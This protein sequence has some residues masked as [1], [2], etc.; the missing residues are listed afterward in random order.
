MKVEYCVVGMVGTN[1][2]FA[3]NEET[4]ECLVIDPGD[5]ASALIRKLDEQNYTPIAILLTHGHFD[6][7]MGVEELKQ[8]YEIPVYIHEEDA[9][10]L[11]RPELNCGSMIGTRV[12]LKA[13]HLLRDGE[14]QT[15]AGLTFRVLHTPGHTPG[16]ACFYFPEAEV[17]FSGDT[18]FCESI[19]RTDLPG[20]SMSQLV[21]SVREKVF[22]LPD[23]TIVYPGHG[24]PTKISTEKQ[25][26]P[27]L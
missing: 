1:C 4:K 21:R 5:Y 15:L 7:I 19:G 16:G 20:G 25:C 14:E 12:S 2:Y 10:M 23:L 13:D 9:Q 6:H 27:F 22:Q 8:K 11:E 3:V 17:V 26:N 24:E 18:L